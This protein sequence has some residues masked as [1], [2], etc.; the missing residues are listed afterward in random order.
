MFQLLFKTGLAGLA[1]LGLGLESGLGLGI[2]T[3]KPSFPGKSLILSLCFVCVYAFRRAF[4]PVRVRVRVR[5]RD[6]YPR[7]TATI[8]YL[9][10]GLG[11]SWMP[12]S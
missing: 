9:G 10:L 8:V 11:M 12:V 1:G 7:R 3:F 2:G 6:G 4:L 5:A